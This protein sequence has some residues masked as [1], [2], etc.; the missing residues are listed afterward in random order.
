MRGACVNRARLHAADGS[1]MPTKH[2]SSFPTHRAAAT[3]ISSSGVY[4][5]SQATCLTRAAKASGPAFITCS[6]SQDWKVSRP[7]EISSQA[8]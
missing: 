1:P 2:T 8:R 7:R 4:D 5:M 3:V 6:S